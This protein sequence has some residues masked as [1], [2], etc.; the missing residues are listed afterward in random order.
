[1]ANKDV[2]G[3]VE[4][5]AK[6]HT[7]IYFQVLPIESHGWMATV[8]FVA[9][10][11]LCNN[12]SANKRKSV[13]HK[14]GNSASELTNLHPTSFTS[15]MARIVTKTVCKSKMSNPKNIEEWHN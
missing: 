9:F 2:L 11:S 12:V 3:I 10:R 8:L 15:H 4:V 14:Y 5:L 1:L 7:L 13:R 6:F